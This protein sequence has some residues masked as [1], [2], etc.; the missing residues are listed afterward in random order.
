MESNAC[1]APSLSYGPITEPFIYKKFYSVV[2]DAEI[3]SRFWPK[4]SDISLKSVCTVKPQ[5]TSLVSEVGREFPVHSMPDKQVIP[6]SAMHCL[7]L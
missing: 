1:K 4:S 7:K 6:W 3:H 2:A 5:S